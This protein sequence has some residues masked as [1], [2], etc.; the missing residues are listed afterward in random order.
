M[1]TSADVMKSP[2]GRSPGEQL[3]K[4]IMN[5]ESMMYGLTV[6]DVRKLVYEYCVS[7]NIRNSFNKF[8]VASAHLPQGAFP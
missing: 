4:L 6:I 1:R 8:C 7:N 2:L 3:G 5:M